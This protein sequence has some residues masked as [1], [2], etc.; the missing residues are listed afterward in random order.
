LGE[1]DQ[2]VEWSGPYVV[3]K[4]L[5]KE[6]WLMLPEKLE[7]RELRYTVKRP[8]FPVREITLAT[9]LLDPIR[10]PKELRLKLM[11]F[12]YQMKQLLSKFSI[13]CWQPT[14]PQQVAPLRGCQKVLSISRPRLEVIAGATR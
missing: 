7:I 5:T 9:P 3:P 2:I 8:G 11:P 4:W 12:G 6:A 10:Y 14:V 1:L 13:K